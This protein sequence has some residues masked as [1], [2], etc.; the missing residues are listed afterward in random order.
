MGTTQAGAEERSTGA[1]RRYNV[2]PSAWP[3]EQFLDRL[4]GEARFDMEQPYQRGVVW[5]VKRKQNL[6]KSLLMDVP[7]PAIVLNDRRRA[8]FSHP[9]YDQHRSWLIA[10]VDGKQRVTAVREF[11]SDRFSVPTRWF[12]ADSDDEIRFSQL[13]LRDQNNILNLLLPVSIGQLETLDDERELFDLINFGGLAQGE[14]D[15]DL[16][17]VR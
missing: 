4:S 11:V 3:V 15:D 2:N 1:L 12:G 5:G 16:A 14:T 9:G 8:E 13:A 6:I 7:V 17:T 10:I